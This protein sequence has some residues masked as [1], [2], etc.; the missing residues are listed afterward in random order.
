MGILLNPG[1]EA[2]AI[3]ADSAGSGSLWRP[4]CCALTIAGNVIRI[5]SGWAPFARIINQSEELL[6]IS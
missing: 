5:S 3:S 6:L 2:F 1:K 4:I